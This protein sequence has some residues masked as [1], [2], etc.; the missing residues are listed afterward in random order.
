MKPFIEEADKARIAL[1]DAKAAVKKAEAE[2]D[3]LTAEVEADIE[4]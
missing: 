3:A 1:N 4:K 2:R